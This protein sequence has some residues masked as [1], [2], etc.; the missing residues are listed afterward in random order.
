M[1]LFT[2]LLLS[3]CAQEEVHVTPGG[4][5]LAQVRDDVRGK[6]ATVILHGG[7]YFL[8]ETLVFMPEDSGVTYM[9]APGEKVVVSG[10]RLITSWKK[11]DCGLWTAQD[12][13]GFRFN[14]LFIDGRRRTRARTPNQGAFF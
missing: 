2:C 10:G 11:A 13:D 9:A 7:T 6:N 1:Q 3:L 5:T 12:P 4:K 8:S 14:Q